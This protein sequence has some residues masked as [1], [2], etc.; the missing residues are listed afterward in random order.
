M[1]FQEINPFIRYARYLYMDYEN[2][3]SPH[4]PYDARLFYGLDGL[5]Q[6][7][8]CGETYA[9][10]RGCIL[11]INSGM[12]YH[13]KTPEN[14]VSYIV[15]NFDYTQGFSDLKTPVPPATREI[16]KKE[17]IIENVLFEDM[18]EF[19][20]AVYV[21]DLFQT[22]E[23][24]QSIVYEY[25]RK[26]R[27]YDLKISRLFSEVL[28][29]TARKIRMQPLEAGNEV[30]GRIMDYIHENYAS[31]ITNAEIGIKFGFHPNYISDMVKMNTGMPLHKYLIH[32][33]ISHAVDC[34]DAGR[35]SVGEVA[36]K[37]GFSDIYYFSRYFKK[38]MGMTPTEYRRK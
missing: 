34:L 5:G 2:A 11:V 30:V 10:A 7:E 8:V 14:Y 19:N 38:I 16:Y 3:Y 33:K 26:F 13:I 18:P 12:E 4:I 27:F 6:I 20:R 31:S 15:M 17:Q 23:K 32:V 9:M 36:E 28:I 37:C 25:M 29:E 22:E 1:L 21:K 35:L 24:M